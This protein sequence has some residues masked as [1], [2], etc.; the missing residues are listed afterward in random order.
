MKRVSTQVCF[1]KEN[2]NRMGKKFQH[3]SAFSAFYNFNML[4]NTVK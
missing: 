1:K 3:N 2:Q 4:A